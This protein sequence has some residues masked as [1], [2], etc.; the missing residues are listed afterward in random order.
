VFGVLAATPSP[1]RAGPIILNFS[2]LNP[3][4][5]DVLFVLGPYE[6]QG[7]RVTSTA[8]NGFLA[9]FNTYG[10]GAGFFFMG[11]KSLAPIAPAQVVLERTDGGPFSL[12]S[13]DRARNCAFDTA[14]TVTF[15]GPWPGGVR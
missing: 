10:T 5:Q 8:P 6:S 1:A 7:F 12:R 14:P 4:N 3:G 2:D 9:G 15:T 13:T 11:Q